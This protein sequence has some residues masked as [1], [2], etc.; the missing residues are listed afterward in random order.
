MLSKIES[1]KPVTIPAGTDLHVIMDTSL[2]TGSAQSGD[3]FEATVADPVVI[4]GKTIIAKEAHAKGTVVEAR[5]SGRLSKP[6]LLSVSLSSVEAGGA[7]VDVHTDPL[8]L[9]GKSHKKRDIV[10]IG[11]GSALGALIGGIAGG[12]KGAAIGAAAGA[13]AGTAGAAATGKKEITLPAESRA[14]FRLSEPVT[15]KVK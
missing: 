8:T 5:A 11:G 1:P 6:A 2:N 14:T 15:V 7:W 13:G 12:G 9:E 3:S 10:A 4:G